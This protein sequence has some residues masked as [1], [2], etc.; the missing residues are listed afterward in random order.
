MKLLIITQKVDAEDDLLGFFVDWIGKFSERFDKVFVITLAEGNHNLPANVFV[1][2]LGKE[3]NNSKI[4]R[5]WNFYR[6]LFKLIP[7]SDGI[8]A[9]MSP[10]FAVAAWPVALIFRKRI[11]LW[12]LHR[13][14][15]FRLRLAEKLVYKIVTA[16]KESLNIKSR[17]IVETGH[18][19]DVGKFKTE[20]EWLTGQTLKILSVGRIS[21]IKNYET[22]IKAA[23]IL[24]ERGVDFEITIVGRPVMP[25]DFKYLAKLKKLIDDYKLTSKIKFVGFIPYSRI[26]N[27][28]QRTDIFVNLAP[29][30]GIDKVVL[31]AMA[32]G[33]PVFVSNRAFS[34]DLEPYGS[35]LIFNGQE[36]IDLADKIINFLN[37]SPDRKRKIA[38]SL[39]D[40][41]EKNHNLNNLIDKISLLYG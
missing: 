24:G 22:L 41:V 9:H 26:S 36:E 16:S 4:A 1:Y 19:I 23:R 34:K 6:Y 14:V 31:E 38:R 35:Y 8:F 7:E 25:P 21:K 33:L 29:K 20:R 37:M 3:R 2:S 11:V 12:Y 13:S 15:T 10:I 39:T 40:S 27:Y 32:A 5:F 18:G 28:Y 17:K 30:G